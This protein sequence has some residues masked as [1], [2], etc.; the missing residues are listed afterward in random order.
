[1]FRGDGN[2]HEAESVPHLRFVGRLAVSVRL[3][4]ESCVHNS[5]SD[6]YARQFTLQLSVSSA[7]VT[8]I[9][10]VYRESPR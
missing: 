7:P 2:E 8:I 3:A 9:P 5:V 1:M 4:P 6:K 10:S